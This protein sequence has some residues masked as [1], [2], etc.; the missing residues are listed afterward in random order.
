MVVSAAQTSWEQK[1]K[2]AERTDVL[3]PIRHCLERNMKPDPNHALTMI[4][5]GL[6]EPSKANGFDLPTI[7]SKAVIEAINSEKHNG[8][9][10]A[11]GTI[12]ARQAVA[13]KFGTEDNPIDPNNV[14]LTFGTSGALYNAI[15]VLCE[16][17]TN[18]LVPTPGFPLYQPICENLGVEYK[19]YSLMPEKQWEVS[20]ESL[21]S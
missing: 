6:G 7:I 13:K 15:A 16:R 11:S 8:Y 3:N 18:V 2:P 1:C 19:S 9:T 12:E 10:Q 5:L 21:R 20:L 4:N 17:G 14:F